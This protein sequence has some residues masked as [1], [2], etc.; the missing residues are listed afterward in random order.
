MALEGI[1]QGSLR[2]FVYFAFAGMF[3]WHFVVIIDE[4]DIFGGLI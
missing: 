4:G 3:V 2:R 1:E